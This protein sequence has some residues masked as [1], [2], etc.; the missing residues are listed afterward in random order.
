MDDLDHVLG[1]LRETETRVDQR[2]ERATPE[3]SADASA[4]IA[5]QRG[6]DDIVRLVE[7]MRMAGLEIDAAIDVDAGSLPAVTSREAY[8][9]AQEGLT[10]ALRHAGAVSV[11]LGVRTS[12][13]GVDI[14]LTNPVD[15][16]SRP[17]RE[18]PRG[19]RGLLG[20]RERVSVLGGELVAGP[21]DGGW[22]VRAHLPGMTEERTRDE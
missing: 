13:S 18:S 12:K 16:A 17:V 3:A 21:T 20:M 4:R 6:L 8:R 22:M 11:T 7:E 1:L 10:N 14:E 15:P 19:G 2:Q 5:P 9:I